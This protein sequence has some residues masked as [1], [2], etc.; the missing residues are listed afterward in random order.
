[1]GNFRRLLVRW[2]RLFI[3]YRGFFTLAV[4]LVCLR[5]ACDAGPGK[6]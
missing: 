3:V 2:E 4:L 5:R 1:L 6:A